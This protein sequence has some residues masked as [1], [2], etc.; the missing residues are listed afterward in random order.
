MNG[1]A[2][3]IVNSIDKQLSIADFTSLCYDW[4]SADISEKTCN[5]LKHY[6]ICL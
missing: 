6:S 5:V 2:Q 3:T 4:F 1:Y